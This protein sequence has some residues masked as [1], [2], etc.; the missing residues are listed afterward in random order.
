LHAVNCRDSIPQPGHSIA[1][2]PSNELTGHAF[3]N[4]D[5]T[6]ALV[7]LGSLHR[8]KLTHYFIVLDTG[9]LE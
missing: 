5:V 8:V 9:A 3:E 4:S 2:F 6:V 1:S 7:E